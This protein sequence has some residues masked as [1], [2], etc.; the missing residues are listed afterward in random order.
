M[1]EEL[2]KNYLA[3]FD[4]KISKIEQALESRDFQVLASLIHQLV[5]SSGSYGFTEVSEHCSSI[6]LKLLSSTDSKN[7]IT[8]S[9]DKLL[10]L[11]RLAKTQ[12][13]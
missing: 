11:M 6:E 4:A 5:G 1:I 10:V 2:K 7:D 12:A 9:I 8:P 3:S 13:N